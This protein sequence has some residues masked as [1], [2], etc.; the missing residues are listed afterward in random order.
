[1]SVEEDF[2]DSQCPACSQNLSFPA[3]RAGFAEECPFC[4]IALILPSANGKPARTMPFPL[5]TPRLTLRRFHEEDRPALL[6]LF[7]NDL[8]VLSDEEKRQAEGEEE[9][10]IMAW[11][12]KDG[13]IQL[14]TLNEI[15]QVG[16]ELSSESKLVGFLS[17]RFADSLR[18]QA[19]ITVQMNKA[20]ER[21]GFASEAVAALLDF[22]FREISLHRVTAQCDASNIGAL[23]M[24][25][26]V[27]M[28]KEGVFLQ[29]Q[30]SRNEWTDTAYHALLSQE[31]NASLPENER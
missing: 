23:R 6:E 17:M 31:Y 3:S 4:C 11:L 7:V 29:D 12:A 16:I 10:R 5:A 9:T 13:G 30:W 15:F 27:G 28:R 18:M 19:E 21:K 25:E 24:L 1:M 22:C 14:T 20:Y 26:K 2:I 8:G